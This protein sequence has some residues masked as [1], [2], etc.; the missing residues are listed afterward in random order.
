[1]KKFLGM[2]VFLM[3]SA[4]VRAQTD[5]EMEFSGGMKNTI[6]NRLAENLEKI[7]GR[8][9][10]MDEGKR[11]RYTRIFEDLGKA[12]EELKD[13]FPNFVRLCDWNE[14][15]IDVNYKEE[16]ET[17]IL[18]FV[19]NY[20]QMGGRSS[21]AHDYALY[22]TARWRIDYKDNR[23]RVIA[24]LTDYTEMH[25]DKTGLLVKE[26]KSLVPLVAV[27]PFGKVKKRKDNEMYGWAFVQCYNNTMRLFHN[28][29][30]SFKSIVKKSPDAST[31]W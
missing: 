28:L 22:A 21:M 9:T 6:S 11:V 24:D 7:E 27:P 18:T 17:I 12:K 19:V 13:G 23:V 14:V 5:A 16:N 25:Y 2:L 29:G 20:G 8:Y 4:S 15:D 31:D 3:L 10:L 1:M 30:E 26:Q